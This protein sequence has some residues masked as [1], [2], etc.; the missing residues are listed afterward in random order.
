MLRQN[1]V[2]VRICKDFAVV[3]NIIELVCVVHLMGRVPEDHITIQSTVW[4][5]LVF[6]SCANVARKE[7]VA[8]IK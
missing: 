4:T 6:W 5:V 8:R 3:D 1:S 7:V 2:L